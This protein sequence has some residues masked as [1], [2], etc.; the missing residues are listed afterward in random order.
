VF[1]TMTAIFQHLREAPTK[2]TEFLSCNW[3]Q[4]T[5]IPA[6]N[7][8][9]FNDGV[10]QAPNHRMAEVSSAITNGCFRPRA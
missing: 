4:Q 9:R 6:E 3:L 7:F 8:G 5:L 1:F 10:I 2:R